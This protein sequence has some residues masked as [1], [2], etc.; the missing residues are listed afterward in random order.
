[1]FFDTHL[2]E[3]KIYIL[4][5]KITDL[6]KEIARL[7]QTIRELAQLARSAHLDELVDEILCPVGQKDGA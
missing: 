7:N 3:N 6:Q 5:G 1:M 2:D 4:Q